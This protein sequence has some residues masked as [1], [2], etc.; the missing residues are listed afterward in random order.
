MTFVEYILMVINNLLF[1]YF[2]VYNFD[3]VY[4]PLED[5]VLWMQNKH[6][7]QHI[8]NR[9]GERK[10]KIRWVVPT[11]M[12]GEEPPQ[13]IIPLLKLLGLYATMNLPAKSKWRDN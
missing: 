2:I 10:L 1:M 3:V 13:E 5:D 12:G 6:V 11:Y 4:R 9:V 7:S 8:W